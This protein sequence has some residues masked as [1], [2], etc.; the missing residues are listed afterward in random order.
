MVTGFAGAGITHSIT[1]TDLY[2]A[3]NNFYDYSSIDPNRDSKL[4]YD[5]LVA[6]S[7]GNFETKLINRAALLPTA[8]VFVGYQFS[9]SFSLGFEY[10]TNFN[11][12]EDNSLI[13]SDIDNK[14]REG[15][16][17]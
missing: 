12:S 16:P 11:L 17:I 14:I 3:N 4:V 6:L 2:D 5:D 8:G 9:R 7:D 10:K 1:S 15:S 13:G